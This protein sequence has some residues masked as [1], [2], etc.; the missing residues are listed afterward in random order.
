MS[1]Q[2]EGQQAVREK[3]L[4]LGVD[5]SVVR[6]LGRKGVR[7]H[8][9]WTDPSYPS[10][11]SRYVARHHPTAPPNTDSGDSWKADLK[12]LLR[13][14]KFDLVIPTDDP[15]II[16]LQHHRGEFEG[17]AKFYLLDDEVFRVSSS[18]SL[19]TELARSLGLPTPAS[20][21]V[22][23]LSELDGVMSRLTFPIVLK[24]IRSFSQANL[25]DRKQV[26]KAYTADEARELF[27]E[28]RSDEGVLVQENFIGNG[29][30]VEVLA[31]DGEILAAFQHLRIHEPIHG[32][33]SSYRKGV[34]LDPGLLEATR[35]LMK[36]L[37][38]TGVGMVEY[39]YNLKTGE[40]IFIEING[41][42]WGSLPLAVASGADFP[43]FLY[44]MLVRGENDFPR[45]FKTGL[46]CRNLRRDLEW[47]RYNLRADASD[48]TLLT[49]PLWKLLGESLNLIT[50]RER[51]DMFTLDDPKPGWLELCDYLDSKRQGLLRK[52]GRVHKQEG[53]PCPGDGPSRTEAGDHRECLPR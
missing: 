13:K 53:G 11:S 7:V 35:K 18:K 47:V 28:M 8:T 41:R 33:S 19:S 42:F 17:L 15:S 25:N 31:K 6:S 34:P 40:W 45:K 29:V 16:P 49:V 9:A 50:L 10:V 30:G 2:R 37:R 14:E 22:H 48:P 23:G 21:R 1:S 52:V 27:S 36:A 46:Y 51:S 39:K 4:L 24:P 44:R 20:Y 38:Y 26:R 12:A 32:G 3:V 5:I 43:W